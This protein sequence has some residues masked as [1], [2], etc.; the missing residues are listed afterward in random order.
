MKILT[1]NAK[2]WMALA[3]MWVGLLLLGGWAA[4]ESRS[5]LIVER[6]RAVRDIV[7]AASSIT[8]D[9]SRRVGSGELTLIQAQEA[10]KAQLASVRYPDHGYL[11]INDSHVLLMH[12]LLKD[13]VGSDVSA[14]KDPYGKF[15]LADMIMAA[16]STGEGYSDGA[17]TLPD[18]SKSQKIFFTKCFE[19]WGWY[20]STGV[21]LTDINDAFVRDL[22]NFLVAA[23]A[24][25]GVISIVMVLII[26]SVKRSLGGEPREAVRVAT[27]IAAGD[28]TQVIAVSKSD[29]S[30]VFY[31]LS[32]MQ[33]RLSTTIDAIRNGAETISLAASEISAAS[34]DL[35]SRTE[36][37]A[38]SLAETATSMEQITGTAKQNA[39]YAAQ[40]NQ[41][42]TTA[43][44]IVADGGV[45]VADVVAIMRKISESSAR[46]V[47]IIA[48]IEGIAF[49]TNILA[50][51]AAVEAARAGEQGRGFSVVASEVR[52]LAQRSAAAAK[53]VKQLIASSVSQI[54]MG[55]KKVEQAGITMETAVEAVQRVAT[56]I[57]EISSASVEQTGGIE[58]MNIAVSQMDAATQQNA[59]MVEQSAAAAQMLDEQAST[60]RE[61]VS[62]FKIQAHHVSAPAW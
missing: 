40:A 19:P 35:S 47:D 6:K 49:Q 43:S 28:L 39:E 24:I 37:Q 38:A 26:R 4:F 22:R 42:A 56:V 21:Y 36:E 31:A 7:E 57:G 55:Q 25:G 61:A 15:A 60:L 8:A 41:M 54:D 48:V 27:A 20:I 51:N 11:I 30:S 34:L 32:E 2:L 33:H 52:A 23:L 10:V 53:E 5:N 13:K 50:L 59:A 1:L 45:A 12:P 3:V 18:G 62:I 14:F 58:Q 9:V 29:R 44:K 17:G 16:K 46:S